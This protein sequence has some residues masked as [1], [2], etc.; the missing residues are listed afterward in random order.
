MERRFDPVKMLLS[1]ET[2]VLYGQT[3]GLHSRACKPHWYPRRTAIEIV[4][5]FTPAD[6][7]F[8]IILHGTAK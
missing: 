5:R 6:V 4:P 1:C 7:G 3:W 2:R 8:R